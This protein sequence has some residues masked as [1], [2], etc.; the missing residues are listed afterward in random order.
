MSVQSEI[1]R[2]NGNV[3]STYTALSEMGA[4]MPAQQ[5]SDNLPGTVRTVPQGGGKTVQTDWNQTDETAPDF[6][7]NKPFGDFKQEILPLGEVEFVFSD[8]DGG[9][10]AM[11]PC[12]VAVKQD[13][14]LEIFWDGT[15]YTTKA[16]ESGMIVFGNLAAFGLEDTGE[17]FVG[18]YEEGTILLMDLTVMETV[19]RELSISIIEIIKV[20]TEYVPFAHTEFYCQNVKNDEYLYLD[21]NCTTKATMSDLFYATNAGLISVLYIGVN[22]RYTAVMAIGKEGASYVY[23]FDGEKT[24]RLITAEDTPE[25]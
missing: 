14:V 9:A 21:R 1:D 15:T 7:K 3:A 12:N 8:A 18:M 11:F 5:N 2:I 24:V 19:T 6:L 16:L 20:P 4:T 23:V 17:P 13:T 10:V 22:A 25:S